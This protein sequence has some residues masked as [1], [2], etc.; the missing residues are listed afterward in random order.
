[1]RRSRRGERAGGIASRRGA[2]GKINA[3]AKARRWTRPEK[4]H[5]LSRLLFAFAEFYRSFFAAVALAYGDRY[6]LENLRVWHNNTVERCAI[7]ETD[8]NGRAI[9]CPHVS[10]YHWPHESYTEFHGS[11]QEWKGQSIC[12][13]RGAAIGVIGS[14]TGATGFRFML[15]SPSS[16]RCTSATSVGIDSGSSDSGFGKI[17]RPESD[18][19]LLAPV[20]RR[21]GSP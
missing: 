5:R 11:T 6:G 12:V 8:R 14:A 13:V 20:V 18:S 21:K 9:I 15:I 3:P 10:C 1:M 4:T 16:D 17:G 19:T 2:S 7:D